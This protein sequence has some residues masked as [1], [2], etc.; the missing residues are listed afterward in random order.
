M[1]AKQI[2][3]ILSTVFLTWSIVSS[4]AAAEIDRVHAI[5]DSSEP[6]DARVGAQLSAPLNVIPCMNGD[7]EFVAFRGGESFLAP[8]RFVHETTA[9]LQQAAAMSASFRGFP[10]ATEHVHLA[11][12]SE[13]WQLKYRGR[14]NSEIFSALLRDPDLVAVYHA[15]EPLGHVRRQVLGYYDGRGIEILPDQV[16]VLTG[17]YRSVG[18]FYFQPY[19]VDR[20]EMG[21]DISFDRD[22]ADECADAGAP[23]TENGDTVGR[24][25]ECV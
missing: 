8:C 9:H 22:L 25:H 21:F 20:V 19:Y 4:A 24:K 18:W 2:T 17:R 15:N 5:P 12:P 6:L 10:F 14:S 1:N 13:T 23:Q 7:A 16:N 11:I 3:F